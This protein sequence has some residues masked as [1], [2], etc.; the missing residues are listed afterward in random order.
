MHGG[1]AGTGA[2]IGNR[3]ALRHGWYTAEAIEMRR[4]IRTLLRETR[5]LIESVS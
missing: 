5:S 1:A 3:N 4:A 2:P